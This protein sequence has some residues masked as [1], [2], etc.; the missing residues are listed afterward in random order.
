MGPRGTGVPRIGDAEAVR[1]A[2]RLEFQGAAS[3]APVADGGQAAWAVGLAVFA[4]LS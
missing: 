3:C 1:N 4:A 2:P